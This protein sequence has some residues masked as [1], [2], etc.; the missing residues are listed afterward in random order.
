MRYIDIDDLTPNEEWLRRASDV[1][2]QLRAAPTEAQRNAII[3]RHQALWGELKDWLLQLSHGKCW[4][5]EAKDCFSYFHVEHYRPKKNA[6]DLDGTVHPG[7]WWLALYWHNFRIC[8]GVG[9]VKKGT[10]F[11]LQAGCLRA[12]GPGSDLRLEHPMLLDP[13]D[14][15]DPTLL[16]FNFE[17]RAEPSAFLSKGWERARAEYSIDRLNLN[18]GPLADKRKLMWA[19]AWRRIK[20]YLA[21]LERLDA[22]DRNPIA[23]QRVRDS[24]SAIRALLRPSQELSAVAL[25]CMKGSGDTR[26]LAL[27]GT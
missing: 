2:V 18:F 1:L 25:A 23:T 24:A 10:F 19:E 11:P 6:K 15:H 13:T 21:E 3:D 14:P 9:N 4:F 20:E 7:Y 26:V 12:N 8:G 16:T 22:D 5:S 27:L 17:G